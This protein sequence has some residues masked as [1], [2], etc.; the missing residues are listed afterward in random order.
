MP[1]KGLQMQKKRDGG[2]GRRVARR[3]DEWCD[4]PERQLGHGQKMSSLK[5]TI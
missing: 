4:C 5:E 2:V 3:A 1:M